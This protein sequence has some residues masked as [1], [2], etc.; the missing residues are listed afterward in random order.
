MVGVN[1]RIV[2]LAVN[3]GDDFFARGLLGVTYDVN[4][5]IK[6]ASSQE[7]V[8]CLVFYGYFNEIVNSKEVGEN[9]PSFVVI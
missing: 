1:V 2:M 8:I 7:M 4:I 5:R 6:G 9:F 3:G